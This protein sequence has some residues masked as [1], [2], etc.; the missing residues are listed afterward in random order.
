ML[1][2]KTKG[3]LKVALPVIFISYFCSITFFTH[4]HVVNGVTIVHSH[5][6][7]TDENGNP[8]HGHTSTEVQ[9][10]HA[11]SV[12]FVTT[13]IIF[14]VSLDLFRKWKKTISPKLVYHVY[15]KNIEPHNRL[16]PPPYIIN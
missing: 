4:S 6:Y 3:I 16:R 14:S 10:I 15:V 1:N 9:L 2:E 8:N 5:P 11:L 12:F 13:A 7:T